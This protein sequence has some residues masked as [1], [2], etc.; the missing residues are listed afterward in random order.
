MIRIIFNIFLSLLVAAGIGYVAWRMN[1]SPATYDSAAA[2]H[3]TEASTEG[4]PKGPRGGKLFNQDGFAIELVLYEAGVPPEFHGYAYQDGQLLSP[5]T[6]T[7]TVELSRLDG[8]VDRIAFKPLQDFLRGQE[9]VVEPHSFDVD[10][11]A[12][13]AGKSYSWTFSSYEG[14]TLIPAELAKEAGIRTETAGP[15]TLSETLNL[16]GRVQVDPA[17]LAEIRARFPGVIQTLHRRLGETV[18]KGDVL[19]TVQ[20]NESLQSYKVRAPINGLI[21]HRNVQVGT[22]TGNTPLFVIADMSRVWVEL[23]VFGR[24]LGRVKVGQPV[25]VQTLDDIALSGQIAFVSPLA[26]HASQSVQARVALDNHNGLLRPGQFM[27]GLVTLAEHPVELAVRQ[28]AIQGFRD[29]Q[30]VFA[31]IDDTYE[32]RMLELGRQSGEWVEVLAGLKPG[33]EYVTGNSYL[34]KADVEKSGASHDH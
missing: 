32:V 2:G 16:T 27:R 3:D 22:S 8:Q 14:R 20:S 34:I 4:I 30:V 18:R 13:H 26:Q 21:L 7:L 33:T 15:A 24:D 10:I 1:Q 9:I 19:A 5:E 6:V 31:H 17:R 25:T 12:K 11:T 23:D 29:F 28:S